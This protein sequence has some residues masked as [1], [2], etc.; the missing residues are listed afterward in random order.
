MKSI[1]KIEFT[2]YKAFH[3]DGPHNIIEMPFNKNVLIY[4]ENG[5]GKSSVFEG[6]KQFFK[7]SKPSFGDL[8]SRNINV[9]LQVMVTNDEGRQVMQ[10]IPCAVEVTFTDS[11][12]TV[13]DDI[14]RFGT[15]EH[16]T[17][18]QGVNY[19]RRANLLGGF[20][21]YREL[22][23]TYLMDDLRNRDEFKTKFATLLI[24]SILADKI[25][26]STASTY[27]YYWRYLHRPRIKNKAESLDRFNDGFEQDIEKI[28]IILNEV[29][30]YFDSSLNVELVYI[31]PY[32]DYYHNAKKDRTGN[33]PICE[34]DVEV[35]FKGATLNSNDENHLTILNEAR[36][37][38]LAISI[39][40]TSLIVTEQQDFEYKI[41]FLDDIFIGLD[42]SNRLPLLSILSDFRLPNVVEYVDEN[43]EIIQEIEQDASGNIV[44]AERP[45]FN[46]YQIFITTYDRHWF[47]V[48][49][50]FFST[51]VPEKWHKIEMYHK[52]LDGQNCNVPIIYASL[53]DVEKAEFYLEKHDY[54]AGANYLRK[55]IESRLKDLLPNH[56]HFIE[57]EDSETG[58]KHLVKLKTLQQYLD[59][60]IS[61]CDGLNLDVREFKDLKNLKDWYFNPFSHDN[62]DTP[63]FRGELEKALDL[64]NR[65]YRLE[66]SI[67]VE[68]G[69]MLEFRFDKGN[70]EYRVYKIELQE[71]IRQVNI[72][73]VSKNT[74]PIVRCVEWNRDGTV[75]NPD[76]GDWKLKT[77]YTNKRRAFLQ[78]ELPV[79]FDIYANILLSQSGQTLR[80]VITTQP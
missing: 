80:Q 7:S 63:V 68:A 22:L 18:A 4:G 35:Q 77:F 71:K 29:L 20:L 10:D 14:I 49:K 28:N 12:D 13:E 46:D 9:P 62:I 51:H 37:S 39:Y 69:V 33:Y 56:L 74:E 78:E 24:E 48:A 66:H 27:E 52:P 31:E 6:L 53:S 19:I 25:N 76:W 64:V 40:L 26:T 67:V 54:P 30:H 5:S 11:R 65:L 23:R 61:F 55:A 21:S 2:N 8:I 15:D 75:D 16:N 59:R 43:G 45:F 38:A 58:E 60:F 73:G 3:K 17:R 32:I 34:I 36:L 50:Q 1:T 44:R 41:L 70:G 72:D 57:K 79:G 47:N 42:M